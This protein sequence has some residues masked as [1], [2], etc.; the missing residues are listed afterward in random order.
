MR[1][2]IIGVGALG[3]YFGGKLARNGADVHFLFHNDFDYVVKNGL[4]VDSINGNFHING[5]QLNA[6]SSPLD[7]PKC[8]IILVCLKTTSNSKLKSLLSPILKSDSTVILVQN[9]LGM[10]EDLSIELPGTYIGGAMAFICSSKI[11]PGHISHADYGELTIGNHIGVEQSTLEQIC[12]DL[13]AAGV[14]SRISDDLNDSRWR[15]LV[16]NIPYNGTTVIMNAGTDQL[17]SKPSTREMITDLMHEVID[18]G[19]ATGAHIPD[20]FA[21]N[22]LDNTD[23]MIPYKPS[24]KLDY[25]F[26]RPLE[27]EYIYSNPIKIAANHG[28]DMTK[29]R[30][31]EQQLRFI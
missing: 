11:G 7:M 25:D 19:N 16:W 23:K 5:S 20:T 6:Y 18:A 15:K 8:D 30:V 3:G 24:M 13:K 29:T 27:I 2:A 28:F 10:E 31:I 26:G 14:A 1:Y 21:Q 22:M 12:S 9:G 4:T 17:M